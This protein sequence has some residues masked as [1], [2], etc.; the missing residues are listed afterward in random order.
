MPAVEALET[1]TW[2]LHLTN[3]R[4]DVL[5]VEFGGSDS[6]FSNLVAHTER[7]REREREGGGGGGGDLD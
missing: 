5:I 3:F 2:W 1:W 7:E 6:Q 4:L